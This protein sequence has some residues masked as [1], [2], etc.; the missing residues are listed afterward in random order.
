[1]ARSRL[2]ID[3]SKIEE[4]F[5]FDMDNDDDLL[6]ELCAVFR[7]IAPERMT[8]MVRAYEQ[9]DWATL[10]RQAHTLKSSAGNLG[11]FRLEE[12][13]KSIEG[14]V[15]M[16]GTEELRLLLGQAQEHLDQAI[17]ELTQIVDEKY[18]HAS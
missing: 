14:V 18:G 10:S 1:M 13:C 2:N 6:P 3:R 16:R 9:G 4:L 5:Q 8:G 17:R 11:A 7:K 12:L 15:A